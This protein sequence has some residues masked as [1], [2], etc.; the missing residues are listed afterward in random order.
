[1]A[2][3][4]WSFEL[5]G[6][7]TQEGS[8]TAYAPTRRHHTVDLNHSYWT[9][10]RTISVDGVRLTPDRL[11]SYS[12]LNP[13]SQDGWGSD[14]L[15]K[16]DGHDCL[17]HIRSNGIT[18]KYDFAVD[19]VSLETGQRVEPFPQIA[20]PHLAARKMPGWAWG[21]AVLSFVLPLAATFLAVLLLKSRPFSTAFV[22]IIA[23]IAIGIVVARAKDL[24]KPTDQRVRE[25]AI[26]VFLAACVA[27]G[28]TVVFTMLFPRE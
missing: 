19:G 20:T 2:H 24:S 12:N 7:P 6:A 9:N 27:F 1:M 22:T 17:V 11:T 25:C 15:F 16:L 4:N 21:F 13:F 26:T 3:K 14:D 5:S 18:Y 10:K 8:P 28:V 23:F